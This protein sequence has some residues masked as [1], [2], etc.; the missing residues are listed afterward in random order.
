MVGTGGGH[1]TE[2]L[3][4]AKGLESLDVEIVL[5][6]TVKNSTMK[7]YYCM[8][9]FRLDQIWDLPWSALAAAWLLLKL[10]PSA[11]IST[12]AEVGALYILLG[13]ILLLC[14]A[15]YVEC[16]AQVSTPSKT[17][18]YLYPFVDKLYVQWPQLLKAY[19]PKACFKGG[20]L[21]SS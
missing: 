19:G 7:N 13:K 2:I 4:F 10:R 5:V 14:P 16:S 6:S 11:I 8:P 20:F 15:I 1:F 21:W 3:D 17:G 12:G 9:S 18:R